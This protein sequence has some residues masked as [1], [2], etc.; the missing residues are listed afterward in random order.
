M[1]P[2]W[3]L[4]GPKETSATRK[5]A[6]RATQSRSREGRLL[7]TLERLPFHLAQKSSE[8]LGKNFQKVAR[9]SECRPAFGSAL[10]LASGRPKCEQ[11]CS[12]VGRLETGQTGDWA[13]AERQKGKRADARAW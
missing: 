9:K 5:A 1:G 12:R 11:Q 3:L 8:K 4:G 7:H 10:R 2:K 6:A 13:L